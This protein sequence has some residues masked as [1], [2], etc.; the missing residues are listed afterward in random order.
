MN[1][2]F[3]QYTDVLS[4]FHLSNDQ[5]QRTYSFGFVSLLNIFQPLLSGG[6]F[7][8]KF[9]GK[10][11]NGVTHCRSFFSTSGAKKRICANTNQNII[12]WLRYCAC[13]VPLSAS[14]HH[15]TQQ[16][17]AHQLY[18]KGET[19][20]EEENNNLQNA[21]AHRTRSNKRIHRHTHTHRFIRRV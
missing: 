1:L 11:G 17:V 19:R 9:D 6:C 20:A 15:S 8:Y 7:H 13:I 18:M 4:A 5:F 2:Y 14:L 16:I 12:N 10:C 3:M 21:G